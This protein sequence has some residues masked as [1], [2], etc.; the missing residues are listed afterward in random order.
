MDELQQQQMGYDRAAT[1]FAPDGHIRQ[2]EYAE[3][4]VRLGSSSIGW[5]YKNGVVI[6]SD[7]RQS[8][9]LVVSESA[10]KINEIDDHVFCVSAGIASDARVL[11]DKARLSAQKHKL[12]FDTSIA[13]ESVVKEIADT[14]QQF[15]QYGGGR[16]FGVAMMFAGNLDDESSLYSID[17]TGNY[18]KYYANAIGENDSKLR[19]NLRQKYKKN[20]T[21]DEAVKE[22]LSIFKEIQAENFN[23]DRFDI[24]YVENEKISYIKPSEIKF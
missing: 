5:V 1:M 8:D 4:T 16:P 17:V 23:K 24:A 20:S 10:N 2:V 11:V 6:V 7:R 22:I 13:I 18:L 21:R 15:S 14:E 19:E 3:K 12:T 9:I